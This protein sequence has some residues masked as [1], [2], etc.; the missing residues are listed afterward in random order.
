MDPNAD[1]V[2][3]MHYHVPREIVNNFHEDSCYTA[4]SKL[5]RSEKFPDKDPGK[6]LFTKV[7]RNKGDVIVKFPGYWMEATVFHAMS[8]K[9]KPYAFVVPESDTWGNM[10]QLL[11]VTHKC[12]ANYIN[13]GIIEDEVTHKHTTWE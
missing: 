13:A 6:G 1:A 2:W 5:K 12:Q 10:T 7:Y 8:K 11:Y 4:A 3:L 9:D